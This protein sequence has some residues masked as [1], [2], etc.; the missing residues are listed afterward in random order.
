MRRDAVLGLRGCQQVHAGVHGQLRVRL[1][2][3]VGRGAACQRLAGVYPG[4][5]GALQV[6]PPSG[7]ARLEHGPACQAVCS[8]SINGAADSMSL[9][10]AAA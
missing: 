1:Q 10:E 5:W 8:L 6:L 9:W 7:W 4:Q 3:G 2:E